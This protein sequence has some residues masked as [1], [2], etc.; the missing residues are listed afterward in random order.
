[1]SCIQFCSITTLLCGIFGIYFELFE[2]RHTHAC[3]DT[4]INEIF[5]FDVLEGWFVLPFSG[6]I[7]LFVLHFI[8]LSFYLLEMMCNP[9]QTSINIYTHFEIA[10]VLNYKRVSSLGPIICSFVVKFS[11]HFHLVLCQFVQV[12]F[13][14]LFISFQFSS[15]R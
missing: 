7:C 3:T 6:S 9:I 12:F 11:I 5:R 15:S 14:L 2:M 4:Q 8:F 1:M 13:S 10:Q